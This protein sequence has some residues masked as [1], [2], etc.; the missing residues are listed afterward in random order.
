LDFPDLTPSYLRLFP[1]DIITN[2]LFKDTSS[3]HIY[4]PS[5]GDLS[6]D[7][8]G[9]PALFATGLETVQDKLDKIR[10]KG[11]AHLPRHQDPEAELV[12]VC[13]VAQSIPSPHYPFSQTQLCCLEGGILEYELLSVYTVQDA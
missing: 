9:N 7:A 4:A 1:G 12:V 5:E 11:L 13:N 2:R 8:Q 3:P 10:W 6:S